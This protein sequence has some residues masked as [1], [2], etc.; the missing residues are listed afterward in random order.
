MKNEQEPIEE[1]VENQPPK[2]RAAF[3][4]MMQEKNPDYN[5]ES[6][7]QLF[8]DVHSMHSEMKGNLDKHQSS[9]EK[10][11]SL[12]AKDPKFG[13]VLS[14]VAGE[15]KSFP[16][17]TAKVYGKQPFDLEGDD[18]DEFEKGYQ[19]QLEALSKSDELQAQASENF[20][21]SQELINKICA[22]N[23]LDEAQS[24]EIYNDIMDYADDLLMGNIKESLITEII[25][26]KNYDKDVQEAAEAGKVEGLN[27][28]IDAKLKK[29]E[30]VMPDMGTKTTGGT[31]KMPT[32]EKKS[33]YAPIK[34]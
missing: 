5:P 7:D 21:K 23:E 13:S 32:P 3:L 29:P 14:M 28:K 31:K 34:G 11:S 9:S 20:A 18:L 2:G 25:K 15:G 8:D 17:A 19:E 24:A 27:Q 30:A 12:V 33:F 16:Y 1:A 26:G 22:D 10:L 6:D 4:A